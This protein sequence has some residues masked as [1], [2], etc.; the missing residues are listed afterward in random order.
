MV[1]WRSPGAA[2]DGSRADAVPLPLQRN[3]TQEAEWGRAGKCQVADN[4][5]GNLNLKWCCWSSVC[6]LG[7]G[8]SKVCWKW[9]LRSYPLHCHKFALYS[10]LYFDLSVKWFQ[11]NT[12]FP[13]LLGQVLPQSRRR[14]YL[15]DLRCQTGVIKREVSSRRFFCLGACPPCS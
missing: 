7:K 10:H 11:R 9:K 1:M 13:L 6:V 8:V 12:P 14:F 5:L 3:P 2:L 15:N 4:A